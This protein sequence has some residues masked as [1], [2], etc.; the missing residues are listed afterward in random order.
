MN[1]L[2]IGGTQFIGRQLVADLLKAGHAVTVLHRRPKH[3]LGRRV[4]NITADRNDPQ[5]IK[6]ALAGTKF[7]VVFDHVYDWEHGTTAAQV[8]GAGD[9]GANLKYGVGA[10]FAGEGFEGV[11][12]LGGK[13]T[14]GGKGRDV[15]REAAG[16]A[17]HGGRKI[18]RK[19]K[20][21]GDFFLLFGML[22]L[23]AGTP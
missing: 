9:E 21:L 4:K 11:A 18:L 15:E 1:C 14:A 20:G 19:L 23:Y 10:G 3:D 12:H 22:S 8:A 7:E 6:S 2:V 16:F 13:Q 17:D 5:A